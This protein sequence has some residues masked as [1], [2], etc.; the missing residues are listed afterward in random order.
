LKQTSKKCPGRPFEHGYGVLVSEFMLQQTQVAT[1]IEYFHRWMKAFPTIQALAG[2]TNEKVNEMWAGLGYYRRAKLLHKC[3]QEIVANHDG[4]I[5]TT[6]EELQQLPGIGKYTAGAIA[7]IVFGEVAPVVDGNVIRV[8][9]R[10]RAIGCENKAKAQKLHWELAAELVSPSH[11]GDFNQSLMELGATVCT[12]AHPQ[13]ITCPIKAH[14]LAYSETKKCHQLNSSIQTT[15]NLCD[16]CTTFE[17][18]DTV[19]KY[20]IK[21][22]KKKT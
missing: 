14:C 5:P 10:V 22:V 21:N 11:P 7:S 4:K 1:V 9:S 12:R 19:T 2:A 17:P 20:P 3:A 6:A 18:T 8:L 15:D 13:C 16:I